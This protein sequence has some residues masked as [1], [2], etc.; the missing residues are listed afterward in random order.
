DRPLAIHYVALRA[1]AHDA[2]S[3][4]RPGHVPVGPVSGSRLADDPVLV[5][6][7]RGS[8]SPSGPRSDDQL[9]CAAQGYREGVAR[10]E[11]RGRFRG[12]AARRLPAGPP[13]GPVAPAAPARPP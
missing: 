4:T 6:R 9:V 10:R 11:L 7:D 13:A 2:D 8:R 12:A 5:R 3:R 1:P